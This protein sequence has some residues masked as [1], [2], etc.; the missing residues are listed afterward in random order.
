VLFLG[1]M[2]MQGERGL[3]KLPA[4]WLLRMRYNPFYD[5]IEKRT[6]DWF[7]RNHG[8]SGP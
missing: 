7:E 1:E 3:L 8:K 5:V 4:D 2:A 6:L